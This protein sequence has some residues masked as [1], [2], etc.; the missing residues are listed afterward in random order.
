M[1]GKDLEKDLHIIVPLL[2]GSELQVMKL[3][4]CIVKDCDVSVYLEDIINYTLNRCG[5]VDL[6]TDCLEIIAYRYQGFLRSSLDTIIGTLYKLILEKTE[7]HKLQ[8][9]IVIIFRNLFGL[10][11]PYL[12][13]IITVLFDKFFVKISEVTNAVLDFFMSLARCCQS[14]PQ[15]FSKITHKFSEILKFCHNNHH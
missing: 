13:E 5:D 2:V 14:L 6:M 4:I 7:N 1:L 9:K 12:G 15:F 8:V 10:I 11:E 3:I